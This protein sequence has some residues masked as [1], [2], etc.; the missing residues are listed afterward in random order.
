MRHNLGNIEDI[1]VVVEG[2]SL[3]DDLHPEFPLHCVALLDVLEQIVRG[4]VGLAK[5]GAGL[6]VG[7]V[8]DAGESL[9]VQFDP[10]CL[11]VLVE[12]PESVRTIAVHMS[13]PVRSASVTHQDGHLVGRFGTQPPKVPDVGWVFEVGPRVLLLGVDEVRELQWVPYEKDRSI[14]ASHVPVAILSVEFD[15]KS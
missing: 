13:E 12:P 7:E 3:W 11:V 14:V 2:L 10:D 6:V 4:V 5:Q 8:L 1:P 15:S 9:E